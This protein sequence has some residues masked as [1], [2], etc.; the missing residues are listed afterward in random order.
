[1]QYLPTFAKRNTGRINPKQIKCVTYG[2]CE[3]MEQEGWIMMLERW[4]FSEFTFC[5]DFA[6]GTMLILHTKKKKI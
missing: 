5:I 4:H 6:F 3:E 1:M 2:A